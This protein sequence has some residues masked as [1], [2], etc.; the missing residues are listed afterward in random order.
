ME[1][2]MF[3]HSVTVLSTDGNHAEI[4]NRGDRVKNITY[5]GGSPSSPWIPAA[6]LERM[7]WN[8][9]SSCVTR[10]QYAKHR[11]SAARRNPAA[12]VPR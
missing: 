10:L 3:D 4:F 8:G 9:V 1:T 12:Y 2:R 5:I 11:R 6:S 7:Q